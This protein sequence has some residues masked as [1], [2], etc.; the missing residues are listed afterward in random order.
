MKRRRR[1]AEE[2]QALCTRFRESGLSQ[3]QFAEE[4]GVCVASLQ[5]WLKR[6]GQNGLTRIPR[7]VEALPIHTAQEIRECR[8]ELPAG[9][10]VVCRELPNPE[11]L[12]G[13]VQR[14]QAS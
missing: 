3:R 8:I 6:P 7:F 10:R 5:R 1:S 11:Y 4:I 12:A 14:L 13:L 2:I 9:I